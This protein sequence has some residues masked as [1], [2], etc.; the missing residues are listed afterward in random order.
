MEYNGSRRMRNIDISAFDEVKRSKAI[1]SDEPELEEGYEIVLEEGEELEL[2]NEE[3]EEV[4]TEYDNKKINEHQ[5]HYLNGKVF[6]PK[7]KQKK[8]SFSET[9]VRITTYLEKDVHQIIR[10]LKKQGQVDSITKLVNESIKEYLLQ[11]YNS[12]D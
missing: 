2:E 7:T 8:Q 3:Y 10:I 6:I 1:W 4:V 11:E 12:N 9:H 5:V